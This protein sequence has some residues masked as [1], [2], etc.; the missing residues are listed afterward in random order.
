G[1][2][3]AGE[4]GEYHTVVTD[5]PLFSRPLPLVL[6]DTS[7]RDGVW[8]VDAALGPSPPAAP[9]RVQAIPGAPP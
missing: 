6:G 1:I 2:D 4:N 7:L 9:D 8:F 3:P 5:G